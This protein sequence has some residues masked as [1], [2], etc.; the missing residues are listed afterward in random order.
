[1][2]ELSNIAVVGIGPVSADATFAR[3]GYLA[4][5]DLEI[6]QKQGAVGDILG[7]FYNMDGKEL[8]VEYHNRL[9]AVRL[10]KLKAM[11]HVI[12]IAGGEHKVDAIKG[13]LRGRFIHTLITDE[14]IALRLLKP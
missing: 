1:M 7:Q 2:A 14:R 3:F 8:D 11:P 5:Q 12:G 13:A 4:L 10:E 6:L 9:I